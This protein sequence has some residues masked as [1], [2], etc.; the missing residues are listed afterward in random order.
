VDKANQGADLV[1]R[2]EEVFTDL[3]G[4]DTGEDPESPDADQAI[5]S[6]VNADQVIKETHVNVD[7]AIETIEVDAGVHAEEPL[8]KWTYGQGMAK[9]TYKLEKTET[10]EQCRAACVDKYP[11]IDGVTWGILTGSRAKECYCEMDKYGIDH[12]KWMA[13]L[14]TQ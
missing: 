9:T 2:A 4:S 8:G 7:Q 5:E 12:G 14:P 13:F 6:D 1:Q 11:D 10:E 3:T